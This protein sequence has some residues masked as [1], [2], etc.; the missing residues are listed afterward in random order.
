MKNVIN[1]GLKQARTNKN[2]SIPELSTIINKDIST[3]QLWEAGLKTIDYFILVQ[4]SN[5]LEC[6]T[7]MLLF[8]ETRESLQINDLPFDQQKEIYDLA[9]LL[10][11]RYEE[12]KNG[13]RW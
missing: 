5:V 6:S 3:I 8:G 7:E 13:L 2:W 4:L 10:R 11:Q 12:D 9:M 1:N